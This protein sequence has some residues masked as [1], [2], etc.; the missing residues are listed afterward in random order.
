MPA[1]ALDPQPGWEVID[2]CAAPGNKTTHLAVGPRKAPSL[3]KCTV[4][5]PRV[6]GARQIVRFGGGLG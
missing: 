1:V 2:A 6:V 4:L 3:N 5:P